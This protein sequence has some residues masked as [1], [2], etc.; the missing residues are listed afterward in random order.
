MG[1]KYMPPLDT[2]IRLVEPG[3]TV[4]RLFNFFNTARQ[5]AFYLVFPEPNDSP[6]RTSQPCLVALVPGAIARKF[7]HPKL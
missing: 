2:R 7:C 3:F 4:Y 1:L 6:A 5:I